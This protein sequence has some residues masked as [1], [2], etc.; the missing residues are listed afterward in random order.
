MRLPAPRPSFRS[1]K[2]I[3]WRPKSNSRSTRLS[4]RKP[5]RFLSVVNCVRISMAW[6]SSYIA[7]SAEFVSVIN[8]TV[9][10]VV[11]LNPLQVIFPVPT[12]AALKLA[13]DQK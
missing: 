11:Q 13:R 4:T 8:P 10:T 1:P 2:P 7:K 9:V 3:S 12:T 6:W 5:A